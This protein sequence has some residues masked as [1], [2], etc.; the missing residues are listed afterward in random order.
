MSEFILRERKSLDF[1][2]KTQ[3]KNQKNILKKLRKNL[4]LFHKKT[5]PSSKTTP[6]N[7]V[8]SYL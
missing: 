4:L 5:K 2:S 6:E 1:H 7:N 8:R 3:L